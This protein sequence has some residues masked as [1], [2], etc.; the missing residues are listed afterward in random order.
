M[1]T[2][3]Y[4]TS[5]MIVLM[6]SLLPQYASAYE[7]APY[8]I[9]GRFVISN[10]MTMIDSDTTKGG[11]S[12]EECLNMDRETVDRETEM[13]CNALLLSDGQRELTEN[14]I[15]WAKEEGIWD[16]ETQRLMPKKAKPGTKSSDVDITSDTTWHAGFLG[17]CPSTINN[18]Y[19]EL[20][21]TLTILGCEVEIEGSVYIYGK[22]VTNRYQI[23][24][25]PA[26]YAYPD[27]TVANHIILY[28]DQYYD[29]AELDFKATNFYLQNSSSVVLVYQHGKLTGNAGTSGEY[30]VFTKDAQSRW[31]GI[32]MWGDDLPNVIDMSYT[33]IEYADYALNASFYD[34]IKDYA[35]QEVHND[36]YLSYVEINHPRY[37]IT[38]NKNIDYDISANHVSFSD[39]NRHGQAVSGTY[40]SYL[41]YA[42]NTEMDIDLTYLSDS[43]TTI[44]AMSIGLYVYNNIGDANISSCTSIGYFSSSPIDITN[45]GIVTIENNTFVSSE[46]DFDFYPNPVVGL[47]FHEDYSPSTSAIHTISNNTFSN[48]GT[49][50]AIYVLKS[51]Y[52]EQSTHEG[53]EIVGNNIT[54]HDG[55]THYFYPI[56]ILG[57]DTYPIKNVSVLSNTIVSPVETV[58]TS[59]WAGIT[60]YNATVGS[61]DGSIDISNNSIYNFI[62]GIYVDNI[63]AT[64][65]AEALM[66]CNTI[67]AFGYGVV[68]VG[69]DDH[70]VHIDAHDNCISASDAGVTGFKV[71]NDPTISPNWQIGASPND[72]NYVAGDS[73]Y[74]G[75]VTWP[76]EYLYCFLRTCD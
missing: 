76:G 52:G 38:F 25:S 50:G 65:Q 59:F 57:V 44:D 75:P 45:R 48:L 11:T 10:P 64:G 20:G 17:N 69:S 60:I 71:Y 49:R 12:R 66:Q 8:T 55:A 18:L 41:F 54:Y 42:Y 51:Y 30:S 58:D 22:I 23:T 63:Q 68:V 7:R 19:V 33:R 72:L 67:T 28:G 31:G 43:D 61:T 40:D 73:N 16:E 4:A 32:F 39:V 21:V 36:V 3:H 56:N 24:A 62:R 46:N 74:S 70:V 34:D 53:L 29:E 37:A 2:M 9:G 13:E 26:T 6:L 35:Y 27:I 5:T 47:Y 1:K 15:S 14:L